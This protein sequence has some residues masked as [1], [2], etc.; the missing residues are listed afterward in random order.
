MK[1]FLFKSIYSC[2]AVFLLFFTVTVNAD[3]ISLSAIVKD[4]DII[5]QRADDLQAEAISQATH[6]NFTHVGIVFIKDGAPYVFEARK[7]VTSRTLNDFIS[8]GFQSKYVL[9]RLRNGDTILTPSALDQLKLIADSF[10]NRKYDFF[11]SWSDDYMY[12]S[13]L[14]W[15]IYDRALHINIGNTQKLSDFDLSSP[16]VVKILE[17]SYKGNIPYD[18]TVISPAAIADAKNLETVDSDWF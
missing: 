8:T 5:L 4:G 10:K 14:V 16:L 2:V 12:C 3:V 1:N 11:F 13:E 17:R 6:S 9:K 15:K 7:G 18:E